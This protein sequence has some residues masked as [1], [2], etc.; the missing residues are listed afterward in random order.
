MQH[1]NSEVEKHV[2]ADLIYQAV[3]S[4]V[5]T[6]RTGNNKATVMMPRSQWVAE[7]FLLMADTSE[8]RRAQ[9]CCV[10]LWYIVFFSVHFLS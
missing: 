1:C 6:V 2:A 4:A 5:T 9:V 3:S 8:R 7:S 10:S